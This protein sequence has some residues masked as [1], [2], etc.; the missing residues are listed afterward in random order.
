M[1]SSHYLPSPT[2]HSPFKNKQG[3][4][5][6]KERLCLW[7]RYLWDTC[8]ENSINPYLIL[9]HHNQQLSKEPYLPDNTHHFNSSSRD[10]KPKLF[11]L[12]RDLDSIY[13]HPTFFML[14]QWITRDTNI[15]SVVGHILIPIFFILWCT[16]PLCTPPQPSQKTGLNRAWISMVTCVCVCDWVSLQNWA[17]VAWFFFS[18]WHLSCCRAY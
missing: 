10:A 13:T 3:I 18:F 17:L 15:H 16:Y 2:H 5:D 1:K 7:N 9:F 12:R 6:I 4:Y 14:L 8:L 11:P